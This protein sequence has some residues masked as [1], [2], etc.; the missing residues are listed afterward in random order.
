M[1]KT[2]NMIWPN[3]IE[4]GERIYNEIG[5]FEYIYGI[6]YGS[7][8]VRYISTIDIFDRGFEILRTYKLNGNKGKII[9][10]IKRLIPNKLERATL[11]DIE[12]IEEG[13]YVFQLN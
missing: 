7:G 1:T 13:L 11:K 3:K 4:K 8:E 2:G 6:E 5:T 10:K 9:A 12:G